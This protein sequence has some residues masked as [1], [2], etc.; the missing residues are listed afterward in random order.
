MEILATEDIRGETISFQDMIIRCLDRIHSL[1]G[2]QAKKNSLG[3]IRS[4]EESVGVLHSYLAPYYSDSF[5]KKSEKIQEELHSL[6]WEKGQERY[7]KIRE[8]LSLIVQN[9]GV[10][11]LLPPIDVI[12][13][14]STP[15]QRE[16]EEKMELEKLVRKF[17]EKDEKYLQKV[18]ARKGKLKKK[19]KPVE[20]PDISDIIDKRYLN[21]KE[22]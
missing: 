19:K 9:L 22:D 3:S 11:G 13:D 14:I 18:F 5:L 4:Y 15:E 10:V 2:N 7:D 12:Y 21:N 8:W 20:K 16:E 17:A 1:A 6:K